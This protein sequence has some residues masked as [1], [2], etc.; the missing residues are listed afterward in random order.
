MFLGFIA[1]LFFEDQTL[2]TVFTGISVVFWIA[3]F[4]QYWRS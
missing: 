4:I 2:G 3:A 1:Q